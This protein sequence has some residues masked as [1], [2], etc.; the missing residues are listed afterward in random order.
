MSRP[1]KISPIEAVYIMAYRYWS[2]YMYAADFLFPS[3]RVVRSFVRDINNYGVYEGDE[4]EFLEVLNRE[5]NNREIEGIE[6]EDSKEREERKK[7]R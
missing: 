5:L 2:D 1:K 4:E 6:R 3:E 7:E